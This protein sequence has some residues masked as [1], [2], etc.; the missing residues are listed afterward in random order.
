MSDEIIKIRK[1]LLSNHFLDDFSDF[2]F[3]FVRV[4]GIHGRY[5]DK[6]AGGECDEATHGKGHS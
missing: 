6:D 4:E 2:G 1:C 5:V 3:C